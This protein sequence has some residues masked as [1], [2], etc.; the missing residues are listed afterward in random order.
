MIGDRGGNSKRKKKF[1]VTNAGKDIV[2]QVAN[3]PPLWQVG[4][5]PH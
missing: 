2:G 4:N 5:L 3:L 1:I